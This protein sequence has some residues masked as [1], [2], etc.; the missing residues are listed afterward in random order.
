[1]ERL[2]LSKIKSIDHT[3][4]ICSFLGTI[5]NKTSK[6]I[7]V[8]DDTGSVEVFIDR[9]DLLNE[10][11]EG[12]IVRVIGIP[13]FIESIKVKPLVIK[14]IYKKNFDFDIYKKFL[15]ILNNKLNKNTF[16]TED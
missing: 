1:M 13:I 2:W 4:K 7:F 16:N 10:L 9:K 14:K 15:E 6:S 3:Q 12:D 5:T 11:N 8:E